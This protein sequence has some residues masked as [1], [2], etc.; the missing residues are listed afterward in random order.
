MRRLVVASG[1]RQNKWVNATQLATSDES[2]RADVIALATE[3][4]RLVGTAGH[5]AARHYLIGRLSEVGLMPLP[6]RAFDLPYQGS[7]EFHNLVGV[8]RG[9][10][11]GAAP[12]VLGAHYDSA[13]E[14]PCADDNAAAVAIALSAAARW[15]ESPPARDVL[16]AL[17][18]AEEAPFYWTSEMGSVRFY[19]EHRPLVGF[20]AAVV[21]DLVGHDVALPLPLDVGARRQIANLLF[22]TGAESHPRLAEVVRGARRSPTLPL[23]ATL[24]RN[25]GKPDAG[26]AESAGEHRDLSDHYIFR[27]SGVP[28]LFLSCGQ[29]THYHQPTDTPDRLNYTK[30]AAIR[31][32]VVELVQGLAAADLSPAPGETD[33]VAFERQLLEESFGPALLLLQQVVGLP[34]LETRAELDTL[35]RRVQQFFWQ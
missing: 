20:H 8:V 25:I 2:L 24:N 13:L 9:T 21:M 14:A 28:Y 26:V 23:V 35:A 31:D 18:D 6:G 11:A 33:T 10:S 22:M 4:G 19:A 32:F 30:M 34:R 16:I 29:W 3:E 15:R 17:F 12:I 1:R 5:E 27:R 7:Y